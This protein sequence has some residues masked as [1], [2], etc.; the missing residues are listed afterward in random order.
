MRRRAIHIAHLVLPAG[1]VG[2]QRVR[3][4]VE[5][6]LAALAADGAMDGAAP[7]PGEVQVKAAAGSDARSIGRRAAAAVRDGLKT[8]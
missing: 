1:V 5:R 3:E 6:E 8:R 4:A 2:R 7:P